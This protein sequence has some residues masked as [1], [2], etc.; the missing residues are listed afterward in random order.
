MLKW[1]H[2]NYRGY[3]VSLHLN[4]DDNSFTVSTTISSIGSVPSVLASWIEVR[5]C[6]PQEALDC[7]LAMAKSVVDRSYER[8]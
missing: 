6:S 1:I 2:E 3:G 5:N 7:T 8:H 4:G